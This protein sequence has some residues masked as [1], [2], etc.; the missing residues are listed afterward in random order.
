[1]VYCTL[2]EAWGNAYT[3]NKPK[4][5]KSNSNCKNNLEHFVS[6]ND[7]LSKNRYRYDFSR[8]EQPLPEHNGN[9]DRIHIEENYVLSSNDD[10]IQQ[11]IQ[12]EVLEELEETINDRV[13]TNEPFNEENYHNSILQKIN[14]LIEKIDNNQG[15]SLNDIILF[16]LLGI[17]I[18]F[19]LDAFVRIGKLSKN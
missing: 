17:F 9:K 1:M 7:K 10:N 5:K 6:T 4:K 8:D 2:Q 12:E 3:K 16:I 13:S 18:I 11:E 19:I 14:E 15:N